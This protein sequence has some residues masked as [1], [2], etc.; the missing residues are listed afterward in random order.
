MP[1]YAIDKKELFSE[2][3]ANKRKV[4]LIFLIAFSTFVL[5]IPA[6]TWWLFVPALNN[7]K[8]EPLLISLLTYLS[9]F[10]C[11]AVI[12]FMRNDPLRGFKLILNKMQGIIQLTTPNT[13][14]EKMLSDIV[15]EI[16]IAGLVEKRPEVYI[17]ETD[18]PNAFAVSKGN[19]S[20][21]V[22]TRGIMKLM[23]RAELSA[24]IAHELSH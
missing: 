4:E 1:F 24:V 14:E 18:E 16:V 15:D 11:L 2:I 3:E 7:E 6:V 19:D 13:P 12:I 9:I 5:A 8:I 10:M 22:V 20:I 21:I 23:N 17:I